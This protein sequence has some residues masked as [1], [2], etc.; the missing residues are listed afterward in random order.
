MK[1]IRHA[2]AAGVLVSTVFSAQAAAADEPPRFP[3]RPVTIVVPYAAGGGTDA[4]ARTIAQALSEKWGESVV[5]D[6]RTG[7]EG[8]IGTQ[9]VLHQ[10]ADGYTLLVQL[11][12]MLLYEWLHKSAEIKVLKDL[13]PISKI[14]ESPLVITVKKDHPANTLQEL[15][16][17]CRKTEKC[18]YGT[19][20]ANGKLVGHQLE[21]IAGT[22]M[23]AIPYKGTSPMVNDLLGDH[24]EIAMLS[25]NLAAP[26]RKEGKAKAFAVGTKER[27]KN[28]EDVPTFKEASGREINGTTWYGLFAK[29]GTPGPILKKIEQ[30]LM[31]LSRNE[32]ILAAIESQGA[33]P[34]FNTQEQFKQDLEQEYAEISVA[35]EKF[36]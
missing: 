12:S 8:V 31:D 22:K 32:K 13:E 18:S 30:D 19:A 27:F 10:P 7:A 28:L 2:L 6:N 21:E 17:H 4:I 5:V 33:R 24:L 1:I 36:L 3:D 29:A 25:A 35:A 14:Q 9:R 11:N 15:F 23:I 16:E 20:T 34:V 26:F